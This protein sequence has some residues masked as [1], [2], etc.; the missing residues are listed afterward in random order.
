MGKFFD[1]DSPLMRVLSKMADLMILNILMIIL[2]LPVITIGASLTAMHYVLLKM[3]RDEDTYLFKSFFKSFKLNFKQATIIWLL[4]LVMFGVF[5]GDFII[6]KSHNTG[7]PESFVILLF[8]LMVMAFCVCMY[9]FPVLARFE[10]TIWKTIKNAFFMMA[11]NLPK[12]VLMALMYAVPPV[13]MYVMP[14]SF[15]MILLFGISLPGFVAALL[16]NKIFK[17][18]E[19]EPEKITSDMDFSVIMEEDEAEAVSDDDVSDEKTLD[20]SNADA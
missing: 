14:V 5:A 13:L 18:F 16:Y 12:T 1:I 8:A 9:V 10:N 15:P 6:M 20:D 19:P 17:R 3:V 11:L 4:M 7:F 2:C